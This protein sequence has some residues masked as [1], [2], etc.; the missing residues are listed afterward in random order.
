MR[1]NWAIGTATAAGIVAGVVWGGIPASGQDAT[2]PAQ[3]LQAAQQEIDRKIEDLQRQKE[4][5]QR[6]AEQQEVLTDL[7]NQARERKEGIAGELTEIGNAEAATSPAVK[8]QRQARMQ[9]LETQGK[10]IDEVLAMKDVAALP[11]VR[12]IFAQ[13][14]DS[15]NEWDIALGPR[16]DTAVMIEELEIRAT[17]EEG[18]EAQRKLLDRIRAS[19][20]ENMAAREAQFQATKVVASKTREIENL[21]KQ[22][23]SGN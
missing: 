15:D 21:V 8:A 3:S 1:T 2:P 7:Q 17:G 11:K 16:H 19:C 14:A 23:H 5:L 13:M 9:H 10:A 18:T 4:V 6:Q 22:F 20:K 12:E